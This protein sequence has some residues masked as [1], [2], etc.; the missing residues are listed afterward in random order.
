MSTSVLTEPSEPS[1]KPVTVSS[2]AK[3][4]FTKATYSVVSV[5][6]RDFHSMQDILRPP[7]PPSSSIFVDVPQADE[8]SLNPSSTSS[9]RRKWS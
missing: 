4:T 3:A 9:L 6:C 2:S 5:H 1:R 8:L 7:K